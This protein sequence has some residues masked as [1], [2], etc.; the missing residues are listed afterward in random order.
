MSK[1]RIALSGGI[2]LLV[3]AC[4]ATLGSA[5]LTVR[6]ADEMIADI[7]ASSDVQNHDLYFDSLKQRYGRRL[8]RSQWC[9]AQECQYEVSVNNYLFSVLR[10]TPYTELSALYSTY[11]G[12]LSFIHVEYRVAPPEGGGP[13]V[14]TQVDLCELCERSFHLHPHGRSNTEKLNGDVLWNRGATEAEREAALSLN[15][16]CFFKWGG[17]KNIT[18][19]MPRMWRLKDSGIVAAMMPSMSDANDD[20]R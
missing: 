14:H 11:N 7:R 3:I 6:R 12:K 13:V 10:M 15:L 18:E 16:Q 4:L 20:W 8:T 2:G 5:W 9:T 17:C 19:L 1:A